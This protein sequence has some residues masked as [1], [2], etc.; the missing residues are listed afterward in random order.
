MLLK[1]AVM[2]KFLLGV[3]LFFAALGPCFADSQG[4]ATGG[5]MGTQSTLAGCI[6]QSSPATLSNNQQ[7]GLNCDTSGVLNVNVTGGS[8]GTVTATQG[9]PNAGGTLAW[10]VISQPSATS[11]SGISAVFSSAVETSHVIK[12]GAGN[13]YSFNVSADATLSAAAWE[14]LI[15]NST[16]APAA[17]AVT[18]VKCYQ[19]PAGTT[20][21]SGA[22][23]TP[24]YF[25]TGISITVST[26][27]T[28][29]TQTD[30]AHGFISADA[31]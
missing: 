18:P 12:A 6:Y 5:T 14:V 24:I 11:T 22:W 25:S 26:A 13:L 9:T 19:V 4:S 30:S 10:P 28:C 8:G 27:T 1:G 29:F 7:T 21:V 16:T 3:V 2:R 20:S 23:P 17:G 15:F 31:K